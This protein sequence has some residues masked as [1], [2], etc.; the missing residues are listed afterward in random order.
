MN[1]IIIYAGIAFL[2][3]ALFPNNSY[4]DGI[5]PMLNL[6]R[7]EAILPASVITSIII[8]LE[9]LLLK[10]RIREIALKDHLLRSLLINIASSAAGSLIILALARTHYFVWESFSL[11]LPLYLITLITETPILKALYKKVNITWPRA[12]KLSIGI[13]TASYFVVLLLEFSLLFLIFSGAIIGPTTPRDAAEALVVLHDF[14]NDRLIIKK[15]NKYGD[16]ILDPLKEY[17]KDFTDLNHRN[18]VRIATVLGTNR[19]PKS[20][21]ILNDLWHRENPYARLVGAIGLGLH[22]KFPDKLEGDSFILNNINAWLKHENN[23][24]KCDPEKC[25]EQYEQWW[26]D[27]RELPEKA[28]ISIIALG[29]SRDIKALPILLEILKMREIGAHGYACE[30]CA[31]IASA[32]AIPVLEDC[33][34]SSNFYALPEAFRALITLNDK[35]AVPLAIARVTPAIRGYNMGYIVEELAKVTGKEFGYNR[36]RWQSW[37]Q[38]NEHSWTIPAEFRKPYDDQPGLY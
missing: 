1:K 26:A 31:R 24:P 2:I 12:I 35:Q 30:A 37:W 25:P 23:K 6:F 36:D 32:D 28:G 33:L 21:Q 7:P 16:R 34:K 17:S 10:W 38:S 19:S 9:A 29:Y 5:S 14:Q 18:A 22:Q 15:A 3:N 4:A 13:N 20:E 8:L 11:I 27:K